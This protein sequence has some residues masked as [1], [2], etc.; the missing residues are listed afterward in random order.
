MILS[1]PEQ[2]LESVQPKAQNGMRSGR[3]EEW[4]NMLATILFFDKRQPAGLLLWII[5]LDL[6][7]AFDTINWEAFI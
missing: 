5:T 1:R 6:S 2:S 3:T 7:K 4:K